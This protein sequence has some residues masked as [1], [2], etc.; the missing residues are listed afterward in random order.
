MV[1]TS[2]ERYFSCPFQLWTLRAHQIQMPKVSDLRQTPEGLARRTL[3]GSF[4]TPC[5]RP[6]QMRSMRLREIQRLILPDQMEAAPDIPKI[7]NELRDAEPFPPVATLISHCLG[8]LRRPDNLNSLLYFVRA[9][10]MQ[11]AWCQHRPADREVP[12]HLCVQS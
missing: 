5:I 11:H 8:S 6:G 10:R 3:S 9:S 12:C 4:C 1:K 2:F 7:T